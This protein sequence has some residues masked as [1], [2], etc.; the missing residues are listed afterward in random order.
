MHP[1]S[2][3]RLARRYEPRRVP[4]ARV[5]R[6]AVHRMLSANPERSV[7]RGDGRRRERVRF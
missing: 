3:R 5:P 6:C 2:A 1:L 7:R 4:R